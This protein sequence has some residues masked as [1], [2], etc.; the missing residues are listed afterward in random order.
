MDID[1]PKVTLRA[2][3]ITEIPPGS[4]INDGPLSGIGDADTGGHD[5]VCGACGTALFVN[6]PPPYPK[7][8]PP[9]FLRCAGPGCG[10]YLDLRFLAGE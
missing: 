3:P 8:N 9:V 5:L 2:V 7:I 6:M 10:L 1:R 4:A